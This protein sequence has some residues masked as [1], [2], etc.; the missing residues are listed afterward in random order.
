LGETFDALVDAGD[1]PQDFTDLDSVMPHPIYGAQSWLSILNPGAAT[2]DV[3]MALL[4]EA[5]DRAKARH[6]A[7]QPR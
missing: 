1:G 7:R 3:T 6:A 4:T 5:H 2:S